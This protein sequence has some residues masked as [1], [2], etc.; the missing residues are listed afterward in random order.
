ME[1]TNQRIIFEVP[2]D[3]T[4]AKIIYDILKEN[5]ITEKTAQDLFNKAAVIIKATKDVFDKKITED[6]MSEL[7]Q[8]ELKISKDVAGAIIKEIKEKLLPLA[9]KVNIPSDKVETN[10][11]SFFNADETKIE[12]PPEIEKNIAERPSVT[13]S[14]NSVINTVV[15]KTP[16]IKKIPPTVSV[17]P[18]TQPS[19]PD[20]YR[21]P[22]E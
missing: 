5:N 7:L 1:N 8:N 9:K 4:S 19:K 14:E 16:R 2:E 6:K 18:T 3:T 13:E 21:E 12:L 20:N 15:K 17:P 11:P 10:T 22:I